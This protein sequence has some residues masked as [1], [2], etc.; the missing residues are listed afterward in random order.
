MPA[1][2]LANTVIDGITPDP[3][4]ILEDL[5]R[6]ADSDLLCYRAS[7]PRELVECQAT[8]WDSVIDWYRDAQ[9]ANFILAEGVI[10]VAQPR[11]AMA[12]LRRN[13]Q[14]SR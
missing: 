6:F 9:G 7:A 5:V 10:H 14:P 4:P 11:E 3:Q 13:C 2:R 8:H 1:T 12:V